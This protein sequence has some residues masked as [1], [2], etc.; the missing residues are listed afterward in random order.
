MVLQISRE[1]ASATTEPTRSS[2]EIA[3]VVEKRHDKVKLSISRL[4]SHGVISR[5]QWGEVSIQQS[6][7]AESASVYYVNK[8][9]SYVIVAQLSPEF[10]AR[11][12]DRWQELE[13]Q[14]AQPQVPQ[15]FAEALR[16]VWTV[17]ARHCRTMP[18]QPQRP[19]QGSRW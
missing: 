3:E 7:R 15:S 10:T 14:V 8:R 17:K 11:L 4:A 1:S 19:P 2:R 13:K 12:V 16:L 18:L 9:D 6:R 5:P